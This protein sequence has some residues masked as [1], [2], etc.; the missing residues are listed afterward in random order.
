[1][2][3]DNF[4]DKYMPIRVQQ[5]IGETLKSILGGKER[6]RLELYENEKNTLMYISMLNDDGS[7]QIAQLMRDLHLRANIEVIEADKRKKRQ[8]AINEA[9]QNVGGGDDEEE[10]SSEETPDG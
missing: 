9:S 1:M 8:M 7:G 5:Q 4:Y 6:R 10:D 2:T 3:H